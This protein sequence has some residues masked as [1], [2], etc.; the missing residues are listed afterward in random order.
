MPFKLV[1]LNTRSFLKL[2]QTQPLCLRGR[3]SEQK[4]GET[5]G[6]FVKSQ[7]AVREA[8][9]REV[10][11]MDSKGLFNTSI[12]RDDFAARWTL[13]S[14]RHPTLQEFCGEFAT[15]FSSTATAQSKLF[16]TSPWEPE[17]KIYLT[18]F[19]L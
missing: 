1:K 11:L 18:D 6:D 5:C 17:T 10:A 13:V 2:L 9:G 16:V 8:P 14:S 19:L 7:R 15:V 3:L 12:D 4:I